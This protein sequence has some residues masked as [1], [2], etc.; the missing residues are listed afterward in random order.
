MLYNI[1]MQKEDL[2]KY[3]DKDQ[4]I[5]SWLNTAEG[6][7][8]VCEYLASLF[9]EGKIYKEREVTLKIS[10]YHSFMN[11]TML[12]RELIARK[13][14]ERKPDGSAYWK[15]KKFEKLSKNDNK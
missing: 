5:I 3:L 12:R 4:K 1:V 11:P 2:E 10:E 8:I 9:K 13:L 7:Q 6:K 15:V 14:M